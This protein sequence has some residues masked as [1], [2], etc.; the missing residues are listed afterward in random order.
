MDTAVEEGVDVLSLSLGGGSEPFGA[1]GIAVGAFGAIQN[2]IFF[3][4]LCDRGGLVGRVEEGQVVKDAGG[5]GMILANEEL[6]GYGTIA[7]A[8]VLPASHVSYSD[9]VSIKSYINSTSSPTTMLYFEGTIIGVKTAPVVSSFSSR[10]P[11]LASPAILKPDII[12]PG[13]CI[14]AAWPVSVENE[15]NTKATFNVISGTS[16]SCPHLSGIA[17]LLKSAHPDWSPAA[18][19]SANMT[20]ADLVN[21]DGK[22]IVDERLL[23]ADILAAGAGHVNPSRASDPGL[24][25]DIQPD[26][27]IPCVVWVILTETLHISCSARSSAQKCKAYLKHS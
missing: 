16:M 13:V 14:L 21:L 26:D 11:S 17:A 27:Y 2:A 10:G 9:G 24:V 12:G 19:K 3:C 5:I 15:T 23:P 6:D 1:D 18:I 4:L 22:P 8:H 7:D 25:Y 20:T